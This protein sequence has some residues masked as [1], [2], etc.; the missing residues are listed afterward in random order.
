MNEDW[1]MILKD[2]NPST[3]QFKILVYLAFR[4]PSPPSEIS[5]STEIPSG[6]VRPALRILLDKGYIN[7]IKD[8]NYISNIPFTEII[9]YLYTK[10]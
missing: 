7:Q 4:G 5:N 1:K 3:S 6:T 8:G 9:S 2:L 10:I